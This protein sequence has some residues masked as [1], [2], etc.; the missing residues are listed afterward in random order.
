MGHMARPLRIEWAGGWYHVTARGNERRAIFRDDVDRRHFVELL[1]DMVERFG[2]GLHAYVLLDNHYHLLLETPAANLSRAMQWLQV[3]H[4]MWFKKRHRRAG[5]LFQGRFHAAVLEAATAAVEVSRYVHLNPVRR[6]R[7]G[8]D[9]VGVARARGGIGERP[10][11][12]QVRERLQRLRHYAWSSYPVYAGRKVK[13]VWLTTATVLTLNGPGPVP[14]QQQA[15]RRY[16]ESAVRD[17]LAESPWDRLEAGLALGGRAFVDRVRRRLQ[18]VNAREQ[19]MARRLQARADWA[20]IVRAVERAK[21][22]SWDEFRD[23]HGDWGRDVALYLG[24]RRGMGLR[25]LAVKAG[26]IDYGSAASAIRR[27]HRLRSQNR[28]L[29]A[30]LQ[31]VQ[32]ELHNN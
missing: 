21:G 16:V 30:L 28:K 32:R 4:A 27:V 8:Q 31:Q 10:D 17:G 15:Y 25:E 2:V 13:P 23:R 1:A 7:L 19:P 26:G 22:E 14:R 18:R 24:R 11:P 5:P 29:A 6:K 3:S 9:K 20:G 12:R